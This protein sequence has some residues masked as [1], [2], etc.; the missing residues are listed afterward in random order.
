MWKTARLASNDILRPHTPFFATGSGIV[1]LAVI[2]AGIGALFTYLVSTRLENRKLQS[3]QLDILRSL[4]EQ[5]AP[6]NRPGIIERMNSAEQKIGNIDT[7]LSIHVST[8]E[9]D[10]RDIHATIK[11]VRALLKS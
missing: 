5:V 1:T 4:Q 7:K 6:A 10:I 3:A 11:E 8:T 2:T 9:A